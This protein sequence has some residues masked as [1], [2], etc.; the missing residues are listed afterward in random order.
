MHRTIALLS[1]LLSVHSALSLATE[2][3]SAPTVKLSSGTFQGSSSNGVDSFLGIRFAKAEYV[4]HSEPKDDRLLITSLQTA[5]TPAISSK[6]EG[7]SDGYFIWGSMS[8]AISDK[9]H[10]FRGL[11]IR[12]RH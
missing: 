3:S 6:R 11:S 12:K 4:H 9:S 7:R 2:H 10:H 8:P 1:V 5:W